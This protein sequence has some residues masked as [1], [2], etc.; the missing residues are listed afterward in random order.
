[1]GRGGGGGGGGRETGSRD[2]QDTPGKKLNE[3]IKGQGWRKGGGGG[4]GEGG[5]AD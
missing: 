5:G 1:M 4:G 2:S 3:K